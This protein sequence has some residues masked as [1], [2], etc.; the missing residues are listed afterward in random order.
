MMT[1]MDQPGNW[2]LLGEQVVARRV[3]L[4]HPTRDGFAKASGLSARLLTDVEGVKRTNYDRVTFTRLEKALKW[5]EGRVRALLATPEQPTD[6]EPSWLSTPEGIARHL[7]RDDLPLVALLHRAGLTEPDLF[8]L[9]LKVRAR[10]EKH[11]ADLLEEVAANIRDLGGWAPER[12]YPPM[13]L[14]EDD[15]ER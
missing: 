2:K 9:I 8:K 13:W 10:R 1:S 15:D 6:E 14:V 7:H 5:P 4:G 12:V 3:E 11:N